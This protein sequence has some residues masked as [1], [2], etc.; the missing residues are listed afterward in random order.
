MRGGRL[1]ALAQWR[2]T[3]AYL[4]G[5]YGCEVGDCVKLRKFAGWTAVL[6]IMPIA[7]AIAYALG[8][9]ITVSKTPALEAL[10][11]V[12]HEGSRPEKILNDVLGTIAE[13]SGK[14]VAFAVLAAMAM[15]LSYYVARFGIWLASK[16]VTDLAKTVVS[17]FR[18]AIGLAGDGLN[19]ATNIAR[20]ATEAVKSAAVSAAST[21]TTAVKNAAAA[22][23]GTATA[24]VQAAGSKIGFGPSSGGPP[25]SVPLQI[26]VDSKRE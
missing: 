17:P 6:L 5:L 23:G 14:L 4:N 13:H 10:Q 22:V 9:R 7:S 3:A 1:A 8:V 12:F 26:E 24:A 19:S 15:A 25:P 16:L 11:S 2:D 18:A 20:S 21:G